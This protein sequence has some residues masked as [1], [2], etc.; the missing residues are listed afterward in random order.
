MADVS[1]KVAHIL[2]RL[3]VAAALSR[4]RPV[5]VAGTTAGSLQIVDQ[6]LTITIYL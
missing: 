2:E 3:A 6:L 4:R 1:Y 5:C